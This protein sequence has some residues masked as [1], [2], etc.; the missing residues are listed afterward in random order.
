M[1]LYYDRVCRITIENQKKI[2]IEDCKMTF[3]ITK[4]SVAKENTAKVEI[5]NLSAIT[6]KLITEEESLVRVSA[7]YARNKGLIEIGQGD[8]SKIK[9]NRNKT[10]VVT[11]IYLAEGLKRI[12]TNPV[13]LSYAKNVKLSDILSGITAQTGF[14]F[15]QIDADTAKS[16]QNGYADIGSV[17]TVLDNL[18][19]KYNFT[20]SVQNGII[21]I[22][23]NKNSITSEIMLLSPSS[24]LIL[25]PESVKKIS[26]K[27]EKSKVAKE[28]K[29]RMSI[30]SLLQPQ[31]QI[32]DIIAVE[33]QDLK[34]KFR[35]EK[36]TH[37]GDTRGNDWYSNME[38]V[39]LNYNSSVAQAEDSLNTSQ[40]LV[41]MLNPTSFW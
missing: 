29:G 41:G 35:I 27:L 16:I 33:S 25:H 5:Y 4:S 20:W 14:T 11:E 22:K 15:K 32:H 24:G 37:V 21:T 30:Q 12:K 23:G 6:R 9:T 17:D 1:N 2:V 18:S 7:G 3:E 19:T 10:E 31:L 39:P 26:K 40:Q 8:I 38:V 34:G 36:I 28:E 13:S